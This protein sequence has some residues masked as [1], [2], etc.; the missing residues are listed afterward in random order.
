MGIVL[1]KN[2]NMED[3]NKNDYLEEL[4]IDDEIAPETESKGEAEGDFD[5]FSDEKADKESS[6]EDAPAEEPNNDSVLISKSKLALIKSLL[7]NLKENS[8]KIDNLLFGFLSE[9]DDFRIGI[10][11]LEDRE[12]EGEDGGEAGGKIIEGVFDGE[13]MIGPDGKQYSV[14]A[15][16]ASKSKLV[17]GDI[18]KLTITGKGT[19]LYKQIGPIERSRVVGKLERTGEGNFLVA[20]NGRKWRVLTASITYFK[21]EPDNE[22]V[23][24]I[25]KSGES[26]WAAVENIIR[27]KK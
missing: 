27:D 2:K 8:E 15:N 18:L 11:Q 22:V 21:G 9:E 17:E 14:P 12:I 7:N 20:A 5:I 13:N 25:P 4:E 16:Y 10:S 26:K 1:N 6:A 23:I 3:E 19:F 24:L